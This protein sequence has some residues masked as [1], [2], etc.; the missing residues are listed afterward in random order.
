MGAIAT[1]LSTNERY[2]EFIYDAFE[3][4][5][6]GYLTEIGVEKFTISKS[7]VPRYSRTSNN[8]S[9]HVNATFVNARCLPILHAFH[10]MYLY[11]STEHFERSKK[12]YAAQQVAVNF[13]VEKVNARSIISRSHTIR[14]NGIYF[15]YIFV[16]LIEYS[17]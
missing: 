4:F 10:D 2:F 1:N 5:L 12:V 8:Y 6:V 7:P 3:L 15:F 14:Q 9:E 17:S 16:I 13:W 11:I